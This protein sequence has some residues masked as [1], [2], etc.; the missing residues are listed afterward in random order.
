M[1][2]LVDQ[3]SVADG[4]V[5]V[6]RTGEVYLKV[7][8]DKVLPRI[9]AG[10]LAGA[11]A[12]DPELMVAYDAHEAEVDHQSEV[13]VANIAEESK[14]AHELTTSRTRL[15]WI[16]IIATLL[17]VGAVAWTVTRSVLKPLTS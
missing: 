6:Y 13:L 3:S 5:E 16:L 17:I 8:E 9:D 4:L 1:T 12:A 15:L 10:D 14:Q 7:L 2:E 11:E